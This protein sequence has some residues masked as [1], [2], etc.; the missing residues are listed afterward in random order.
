MAKVTRA[1]EMPVLAGASASTPLSLE[2]WWSS[3][4]LVVSSAPVSESVPC[5][6]EPAPNI[7]AGM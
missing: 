6:G 7:A 5:S 3:R 2:V 1:E 4:P